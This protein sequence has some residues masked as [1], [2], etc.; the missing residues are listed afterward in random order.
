MKRGRA[1][2][3]LERSAGLDRTSSRGFETWTMLVLSWIHWARRR[4][5]LSNLDLGSRDFDW[6]KD[7]SFLEEVFGPL[8]VC[9]CGVRAWNIMREF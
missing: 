5:Y 6:E 4:V 8:W 2:W 7:T 1:R 3:T 9:A